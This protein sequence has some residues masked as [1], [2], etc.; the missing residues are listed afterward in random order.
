MIGRTS[1]I[2]DLTAGPRCLR[3]TQTT[4]VA[5][6]TDKIADRAGSFIE[7]G[8]CR[9]AAPRAAGRLYADAADSWPA[10]A[11]LLTAL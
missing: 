6:E 8:N 7:R 9:R 4:V 11:G 1:D 3:G 5:L 10:R 2:Y